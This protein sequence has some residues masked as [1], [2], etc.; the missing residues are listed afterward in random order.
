MEEQHASQHDFGPV[1]CQ[2]EQALDALSWSDAATAKLRLRI[3]EAIELS[4]E[5][6]LTRK[7]SR[8]G[9]QIIIAFPCRHAATAA[10]ADLSPAEAQ[11]FQSRG[12]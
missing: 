6:E 10:D 2:I 1:R 7:E 5:I 12:P 9:G 11:A 8:R 4:Y 3:E